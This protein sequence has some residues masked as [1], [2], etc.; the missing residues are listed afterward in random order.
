MG[1]LFI[2]PF[3]SKRITSN[4]ILLHVSRYIHLNLVSSY[5]SDYEN[6]KF[7]IR[8]SYPIYLGNREGNIVNTKV[9]LDI[10][11]TLTNYERF[12]RDQVD[13]QKKLQLIKNYIFE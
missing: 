9:I 1:G 7:D 6:S 13:Y 3:K 10:I 5:L 2:R 12:V 4:E 8:S 11:G